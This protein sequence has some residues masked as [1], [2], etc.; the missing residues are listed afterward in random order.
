[1]V[2]TFGVLAVATLILVFV[3]LRRA[4]GPTRNRPSH[5]F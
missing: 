3:F 4:T 5:R 2:G 1:V